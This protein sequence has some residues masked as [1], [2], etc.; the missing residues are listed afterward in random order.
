MDVMIR[1]ATSRDTDRVAAIWQAGWADGHAGNVPDALVRHRTPDVFAK[2]AAER[3]AA[4][5]VAEVE[6]RPVGFVVVV[7]DEVEQVYVDAAA[8]GSGVAG[9]LRRHAE[10]LVR[11]AGH[12][13]AWLA[14]VAGNARARAFYERQGWHDGGGFDYDAE[15]AGGGTVPVPCRRYVVSLSRSGPV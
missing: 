8:R 7:G 5:W 12:D 13:T 15:I 4:T 9:R 3:V 10:D 2:L 1:A 11:A 14:V 6:G